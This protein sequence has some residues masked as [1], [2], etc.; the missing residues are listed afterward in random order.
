VG[1]LELSLSPFFNDDAV[2]T[3]VQ[4]VDLVGL[5]TLTNPL[6]PQLERRLVA[7]LDPAP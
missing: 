1:R 7:T 5:S 2:A 6:D 3:R 4:G